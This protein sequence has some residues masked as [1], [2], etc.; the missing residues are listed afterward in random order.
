MVTRQ[1]SFSS[2]TRLATG[3][4]TPSRNSSPNSVDPAM[5]RSGPE[6]DAG[7]V[8]GQDQ[9]RDAAVAAVLG[10]GAHQQLAEVGHLGV[11]RPD[12]LPRDDVLVAVAHGPGAQRRQVAPGAGLGEPLAPHL[13]AAQ[14]GGE[15]P[16]PLL[17][18]PLHDHG[19]P[20]VQQAHEVH[21]HVG[22]VGPLEL[23]EVDELLDGARA[24]AAALDGPVDARVPGVE[25]HPLPRRV[26]GAPPGPVQVRRLLGQRGQDLGQPGA[27]LGAKGL[28]ALGVAQV[29]VSPTFRRPARRRPTAPGDRA[30]RAGWRCPGRSCGACRRRGAPSGARRSPWCGATSSP[31]GGSRT[32]R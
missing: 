1:P 25:E 29:H 5:V 20:G 19:G 17:G 28:L 30:R 32:R 8:H 26:V 16:G 12:L 4:R 10:P 14:D 27:Q 2:P 6:V 11:R 23:L 13:V 7:S 18:G 24:P 21:P 9:P 3:T 15:E 31:S 22:G